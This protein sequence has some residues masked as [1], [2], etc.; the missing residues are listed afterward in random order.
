MISAS[1]FIM[2]EAVVVLILI[3]LLIR[4]IIFKWS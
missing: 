4:R 2:L 1:I 3:A